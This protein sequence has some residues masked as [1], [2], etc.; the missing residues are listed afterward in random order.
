MDPHLIFSGSFF[1][2]WGPPMIQ[3]FPHSKVLQVSIVVVVVVVVVVTVVVVTVV[4]VVVTVVVVV[5]VV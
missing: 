2:N 1:C 4:V 5:V 3:G